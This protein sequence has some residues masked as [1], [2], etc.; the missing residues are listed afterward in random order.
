MAIR[1][2]TGLMIAQH[3]GRNGVRPVGDPQ[4]LPDPQRHHLPRQR[5]GESLAGAGNPGSGQA[6]TAASRS[7]RT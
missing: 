4:G 2:A 3:A 6:T 7:W 5:S 1:S